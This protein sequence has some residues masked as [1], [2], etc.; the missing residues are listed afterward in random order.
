MMLNNTELLKITGGATNISGTL[1]NAV[2][3]LIDTVLSIGRVIGT[4]I[5]MTK[6][7]TKC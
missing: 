1:L 4:A 7:G 6:S 5:R 2:A 3:K